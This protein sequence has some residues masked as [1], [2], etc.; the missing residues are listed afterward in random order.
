MLTRLKDIFIGIGINLQFFTTIPLRREL[1]ME[2]KHLSYALYSFPLLGLIQ[3][4]IYALFLFIAQTLPLSDILV[5]LVLW[6][7]LIA[8]SGGIHL[9]GWID[10]SDAYFSFREKEKRLEIMKDPRVGAFGVL[11]IIVFLFVRFIVLYELI[12]FNEKIYVW[13]ILI[14]FLGK[15][16]LGAYLQALPAARE[17]GMASFF[18]QGARKGIWLA[19]VLFL[20]LMGLFLLFYAKELLLGYGILVL[21]LV[22]LGYGIAGKLVKNFGGITGDTLGASSE[23]MELALWIMVLLLHSFAMV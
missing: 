19:Y 22:L 7:V 9:D 11:S 15:M 14:P 12:G 5:A 23:G 20:L 3:G 1:P 2:Q 21:T 4:S 17:S 18:K 10:T 16:I 6:L 8:L 13:V